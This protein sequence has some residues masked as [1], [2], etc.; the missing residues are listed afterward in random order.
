MGPNPQLT[1]SLSPPSPDRPVWWSLMD[2]SCPAEQVL[3]GRLM[4]SRTASRATKHRTGDQTDAGIAP[5]DVGGDVENPAAAEKLAVGAKD[6]F[7][8]DCSGPAGGQPQR[9]DRSRASHGVTWS[10]MVVPT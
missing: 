5:R 7:P 2:P 9:E 1:P 4:T 3:G 6:G 8:A 10:M